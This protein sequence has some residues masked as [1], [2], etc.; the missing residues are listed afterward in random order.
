MPRNPTRKT[1][2]ASQRLWLLFA[3][4][5]VVVATL[6]V[7]AYAGLKLNTGIRAYVN[8]ESLYSKGQKDAVF[9][10]QEYL[11][12]GEQSAWQRFEDN[13]AVPLGDR[14][15]RL[16]LQR[17]RPDVQAAR[18]GFLAGG[19]HPDDI[20]MMI[21][22]FRWMRWA[23]HFARTV[24]IWVRADR[25]IVELREAGAAARTL[26]SRAGPRTSQVNRL[27]QRIRRINSELRPLEEQFSRVMGDAARWVNRVV[28]AIF[29]G[30]S[31][32][33]LVLGVV[34]L[35]RI[36]GR[37]FEAE[38]H[39][40]ATFEEAGVGIAHIGLD[41]RWRV[42]NAGLAGMLGTSADELA[43][44]RFADFAADA[45]E[46]SVLDKAGALLS[47]SPG[48]VCLEKR[49]VRSNGRDLWARL[50]ITL[51]RDLGGKPLYFIA[52]VED[53]TESRKLA[54]QLS[55]QASHDVVTGLINRREF[56]ARLDR[57]VERAAN[58]SCALI[59]MD[60]DQFK[61]VND[62]CGHMAGD[63][64][65]AQIGP[66]IRSCVRSS[67]SV[68]R[69]GG[70]EFAV[71][72]ER[73]PHGAARQVAEKIRVALAQFRF[74]WNERTFSLSASLGVMP[75]GGGTGD[76][77]VDGLTS[78]QVLSAA[79]QACYEAKRRGRNHVQLGQLDNPARAEQRREIDRLEALRGA[80]ERE[81]LFLV[82]ESIV[83]AAET[84]ARLLGCEALVRVRRDDDTV[85][86]PEQFLPAA[87]RFGLIV[88]VDRWVLRH[89]L[90]SLATRAPGYDDV[91]MIAINVSGLSLSNPDYID[92][93]IGT[94]SEYSGEA[95]R[96]CLEITE[97]AA[98][99]NLD[100]VRHLIDSLSRFG[101]R[102]SLDDFGSG[103][104]SF[105]YLS[106]LPVDFVKI[107]GLFVRDM[108]QEPIHEAMVRS[109]ND[110]AHS[111]GK[112]TVAECVES[113]TVLA[114][115]CEIGVDYLQGYAVA[116]PGP[117]A[118]LRSRSRARRADRGPTG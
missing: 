65:L 12:T 111:M 43:G 103:F 51:L 47:G 58:Q 10:L 52:V 105:A 63:A 66:L 46:A 71:L 25:Y 68:A 45:D 92:E 7:L 113:D 61:V 114:L 73:C 35:R 75:F 42:A 24:D 100:K 118:T 38:A 67:D 17:E 49:L 4:I 50:N 91:D 116:P 97:T 72:L 82:F 98:I 36:A 84:G 81:T 29:G 110:V 6:F 5:F 30:A 112:L 106:A 90:E 101:C 79:D 59:Y 15:A 3:V 23:P 16:A 20:G 95:G 9:S 40:R 28:I 83:S 34:L 37:V 22:I 39:F 21:F 54:E 109:I 60:L 94:V 1:G 70:D 41:G 48:P 56:E 107:D 87:E 108:D 13:L 117:L 104:S 102:F 11:R 18:D 74:S 62:Q 77:R 89:V 26:V 80:L 57:A 27:Q 96:L 64:L 31:V 8:G 32:L 14:R 99:G 76:E 33:V 115:L 53:I 2:D 44:R 86:E 55:F 69:V 85:M 93:A 88:D 78:A 19:N